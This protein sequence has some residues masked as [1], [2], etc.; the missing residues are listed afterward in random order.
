MRERIETAV[1]S[2][3]LFRSLDA[4]ERN[5]IFAGMRERTVT[6][7]E[8]VIRQGEEGDN[9]YVVDQ[10]RFSVDVNGREMVQIGPGGSFGELALMYNT[11]RAATVRALEDGRLFAVDRNTFRRVI[12]DLAYQ[13]RCRYMGFLRTVPLLATLSESEIGCIADALEPCS[14]PPGTPALRQGDPGD[15]F[16]IIVE[17]EAA[18]ER[19]GHSVGTLHPGDYFGELALLNRQPRAATVSPAGS[20]PLKCVSLNTA[21]FV[22][23]LGP[24]QDILKRNEEHYARYKQYLVSES[25]EA[26]S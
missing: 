7:G 2:N 14:F 23:L 4:E 17:G 19:D 15:A 21:D 22:R 16:Y 8:V 5:L 10:G 11:Q 13:K 6:A 26:K 25:P 1:R 24:L 12:I 20:D 3:L 18:V 9:F